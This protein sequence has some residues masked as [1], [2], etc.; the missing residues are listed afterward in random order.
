MLL[1]E[2]GS[3]NNMNSMISLVFVITYLLV[4]YS[5]QDCLKVDRTE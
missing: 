5:N 1:A 4:L 3:I 2:A